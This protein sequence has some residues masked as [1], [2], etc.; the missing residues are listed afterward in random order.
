METGARDQTSPVPSAGRRERSPRSTPDAEPPSGARR[1][2]QEPEGFCNLKGS[3]PEKRTACRSVFTSP[4]GD[5]ENRNGRPEGCG[6]VLEGRRTGGIAQLVERQLCK[7]DVRSSNLLASTTAA[8]AHGNMTAMAAGRE[9][10]GQ[11]R[12]R[13]EGSKPCGRTP[14]G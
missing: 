1:G 7:L 4:L 8:S 6:S 11:G 10:A 5:P 3:V 13:Q 12:R 9:R 2:A 14:A